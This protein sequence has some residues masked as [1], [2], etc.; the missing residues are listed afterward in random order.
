M[1]DEKQMERLKEARRLDRFGPEAEGRVKRRKS[2][3]GL[4]VEVK[5]IEFI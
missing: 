1:I 4:H 3:V 2:T 5:G